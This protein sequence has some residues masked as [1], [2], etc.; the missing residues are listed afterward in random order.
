MDIPGFRFRPS[1]ENDWAFEASCALPGAPNMFPHD[2]DLRGIGDA[3]SVCASC[4]VS[5]E[6]LA[7][8]L[9]NGDQYGVWGGY[10]AEERRLIRRRAARRASEQKA[11]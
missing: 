10:T 9:R 4:P 6:C 2:N 3:K 1:P 5:R 11:A 7:S 8:A